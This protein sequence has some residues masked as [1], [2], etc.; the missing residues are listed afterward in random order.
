MLPTQAPRC[1]DLGPKPAAADRSCRR[2]TLQMQ[3]CSST[4]TQ[5]CLAARSQACP[6]PSPVHPASCAP[7]PSVVGA[8]G[9]A[10]E[11][12]EPGQARGRGASAEG[13][14]PHQTGALAPPHQRPLQTW[15]AWG[16][17]GCACLCL[18][19]WGP[20]ARSELH[21]SL[22]R[23][24]VGFGERGCSRQVEKGCSAERRP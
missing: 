19:R 9:A 24:V 12:V 5:G 13:S 2:L 20:P 18:W 6:P 22:D 17:G 8:P 1:H 14:Q 23:L 10:A 21:A 4:V 7:A 3:G 16:R 11:Q 15:R